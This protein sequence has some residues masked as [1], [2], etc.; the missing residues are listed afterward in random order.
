M[1]VWFITFF[2]FDMF[3]QSDPIC[4][5]DEIEVEK[6]SRTYRM[7]QLIIFSYSYNLHVH[8]IVSTASSVHGCRNKF[9]LVYKAYILGK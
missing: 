2:L 5:C 9:L 4:H 7:L 1:F 3:P 8:G 6:A